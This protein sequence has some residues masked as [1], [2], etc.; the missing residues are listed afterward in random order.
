MPEKLR[1][2]RLRV[3]RNVQRLRRLRGLSQER[4]AEVVG[5]TGKHIGQVERGEVNVGV[6]I[7]CRLA[8]ALSADVADLFL[9]ARRSRGSEPPYVLVPQRAVDQLEQAL[10]SMKPTRAKRAPR[11]AG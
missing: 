5:N 1:A 8:I 10:R 6:D 4:L 11:S 9:G 2:V 3:G 7:L